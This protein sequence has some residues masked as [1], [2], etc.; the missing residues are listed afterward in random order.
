MIML[1]PTKLNLSRTYIKVINNFFIAV[2]AAIMTLGISVGANAIPV[3]YPLFISNPVKPIMM[4]NMSRDHQLFFK[5]YDDY[6]DIVDMRTH[7]T[8][9]SAS[10]ENSSSNSSSSPAVT[11]PNYGKSGSDGVADTTYI[12]QYRY[13]GYFDSDKCY[14]Y[15]D[16]VFSPSRFVDSTTRYCNTGGVK[17]EWSGNLLNWATMTRLDAVRKILYGG[18]RLVD[19]EN[20]TILE[21][22]FIPE[23]AHAFAKYY[24]GTDINSLTPFTDSALTMGAATAASGITFCNVTSPSGANRVQSQVVSANPNVAP[25]LKVA[26]G[27]FSLWA[28]NEGYQCRWD[29][30]TNDNTAATTQ[31][32]AYSAS[33]K[34]NGSSVGTGG[35]LD[36]LGDGDYAVRV[37][38]C[39]ATLINETN[40]EGCKRYDSSYSKPIGLLQEYGEKDAIQFGLMT[41]SYGKNKSGGVLRKNIGTMTD[42]IDLTT[43]QFINPYKDDKNQSL[44][45]KDSIIR[46]LNALTI[47]GYDYSNGQ[48]NSTDSCAWGESFFSDDKCTNWGNPQSEIYLES[49]RYLAGEDATG[50]FNADDSR[51]ISGLVTA[52]WVKPVTPANYCAPL[53]VLQFNAS[54]SSYDIDQLDGAAQVDIADLS[55]LT[56]AVGTAEKISGTYFVGISGSAGDQLCTPKSI[57]ALA[58]VNGTCPDAPRLSGGYQIAG[59][60]YSARKNGFK[61]NGLP[62]YT[63]SKAKYNSPKVHTYGV[64]LAPA[65]PKVEIPVPGNAAG[66]KIT[67]LPACR[68]THTNTPTNC[69]IVDFKII[70]QNHTGNSYTGS[71]YVNWED[72]EQGGDYDQDMWG[73]IK[74]TVTDTNVTV[75]TKVMA[76][77]TDHSLGFG[78]VIGGTVD[79]AGNSTDG[80]KVQSGINNFVYGDYCKNETG[81]KCTCHNNWQGSCSD[82]EA[83]WRSQSFGINS[84]DTSNVKLLERPLYY[85]AKW[86]GYTNDNAT[87][88][89]I[90]AITTPPTYFYVTDPRELAKSMRDA[91]N[92]IAESV[93]S[94]SGVATNST[95]LNGS[96]FL[97]Q[98]I[99]NSDNW[100]G[101]L[102]AF[103][104][105]SNGRLVKVLDA[106]LNLVPAVST[107]KVQPTVTGRRIYTLKGTE[108]INFDWNLLTAEQQDYFRVKGD[109]PGDDTNPEKR[110]NWLRGDATNEVTD[111][112]AG[113][114]RLR[115][116]GTGTTRNIYGD[117][118][119]STPVYVGDTNFRYHRL[120][121]GGSTYAAYLATKKTRTAKVVVGA[122]D[123]MVHV[124]NATTLEELYA[125]VPNLVFP[126]LRNLTAQNYGRGTNAHQYL[127]DGP[128]TVSDVYDGTNWR[129][130]VV[131]SLGGGGRG[132]FGLDVT[133]DSHPKILFEISDKDFPELGYVLGKPIVM[134]MKNGNWA[135]IFGN[136]DSSGRLA[137]S[138][139]NIAAVDA[140][141]QLF[142]V[143]IFSPK[144][145][146]VI[147]A[148]GAG[149][150][151]SAPAVL[152]DMNGVA[153]FVYAGDLNGQLWKFDVSSSSAADWQKA[154]LVFHAKTGDGTPKEQPITAAPTLGVNSAKEGRIAVYFGT[155][156]YFEDNDHKIASTNPYHS[157][158][159]ITDMGSTVTRDTLAQKE[160][161]SFAAAGGKSSR[162]IKASTA[163]V[164]WMNNNGWYL[165]FAQENEERVITK[166]LLIADKLVFA[167]IIPSA[168]SCDYGG[169]SWV[170][171]VPAIGNKFINYQVLKDPPAEGTMTT[172]AVGF[173]V[174]ETEAALLI[175]D[176]LGNPKDLKAAEPPKTTGRQ[177]WRELD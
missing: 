101:A 64:A 43:G 72:S 169:T 157:F 111:S 33:P 107:D 104:F 9:S 56:N 116:R 77:A 63:D 98:A 38:V 37:S 161:E 60:A 153:K 165:N 27:N 164:D 53:N 140:Q 6:S 18:K 79:T 95:S 85:A 34:R 28:S 51:K 30:G 159:A 67:I 136:G 40:E 96:S 146:T 66:K 128:L 151:L 69:A 150:G 100:R 55:A 162:R 54:T 22:A 35:A 134:P 83:V 167:T 7:I 92:S 124:F 49:L 144:T 168:T 147:L 163:T 123:G 90:A 61:I 173:G 149:R 177:S 62:T 170:I 80:F 138:K 93:G 2:S 74:Y 10:S 87:A 160:I 130:I 175:G 31:I 158:Y 176:I 46:T 145:D 50:D 19:D 115:S 12:H 122:N 58:T 137:D 48:Y 16:G 103:R 20:K 132:V 126:K 102:N 120:T 73:L 139:K 4:L 166:A 106:K 78:Y 142:V 113:V 84:A 81:K 13:Y 21:R 114:D 141:S 109:T 152:P 99:F 155:G 143:D 91:F 68:N 26:R 8:G 135:A 76:Q 112:A 3:Q 70:S 45:R 86:G 110:F 127:V 42:E 32:N 119:N 44:G 156:K 172:A 65:V 11:N 105:D 117:I 88:E 133:D 17:N 174:T 94:S 47:Y 14:T 5:L 24:N 171:E 75:E 131:G 71:L 25:F 108:T 89:Q 118:V 39:V 36:A 57:T 52:S 121:K 15:S 23:D 97:Y 1:N 29:N 154:Y 129:T 82:G 41:G 125:Y 59:L 148:T